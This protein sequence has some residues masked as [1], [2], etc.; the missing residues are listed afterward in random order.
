MKYAFIFDCDIPSGEDFN[1]QVGMGQEICLVAGVS[2]ISEAIPLAKKLAAEGF[3]TMGFCG[4]FDDEMIAKIGEAVGPDVAVNQMR[5]LPEQQK[6]LDEMNSYREYGVLIQADGLTG[7]A[8]FLL[9]NDNSNTKVCFV[10]NWENAKR[11]ATELYEEG[12]YF[13]ECCGWFKESMVYELIDMT[14]GTIPIGST[15]LNA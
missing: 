7:N 6:M 3:D 4:A 1:C 12:I 5:Y 15:A 11:A 10:P 8:R 2:P 13:I 14:C 9:R